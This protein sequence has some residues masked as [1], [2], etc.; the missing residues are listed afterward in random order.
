MT[1]FEIRRCLERAVLLVD[2]REQ[3][4]AALRK[5]LE[6]I[7][8]PYERVKLNAGDYSIKCTDDNG[9]EINFSSRI[10]IERKMSADELASCYTHGREHFEREFER[11]KASGTKMYI[12]CENTSWENIYNGKY[13]S[14]FT[15]AAFT[16]SILAWS[17]RYGYQI[18]FCKSETAPKLIR[19]ILYREAK[20]YLESGGADG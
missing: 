7:G 10:A 6:M 9:T 16:A 8:L 13:R 5:R 18:I 19:D 3:D 2:T 20:E 17:V 12:L 11:A 15:P 1:P 14:K 4:T